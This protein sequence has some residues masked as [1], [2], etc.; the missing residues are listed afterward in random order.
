MNELLT[1]VIAAHGGLDRW[2][3]FKRV[4][5]TY[6]GGGETSEPHNMETK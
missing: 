3:R 2:N 6:V 5:G 1:R 4:T